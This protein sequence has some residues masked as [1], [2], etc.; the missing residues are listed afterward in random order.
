[1]CQEL[2]SHPEQ[3]NNTLLMCSFI[4]FAG[5]PTLEATPLEPLLAVAGD[6]VLID[7]VVKS[8][9]NYTVRRFPRSFSSLRQVASKKNLYEK[10]TLLTFMKLE[11]LIFSERQWSHRS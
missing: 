2:L 11:Y 6:A 10:I 5:A 3:E 8:L 7:C 1:M 9:Q 4:R